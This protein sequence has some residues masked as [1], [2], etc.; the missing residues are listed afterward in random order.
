MPDIQPQITAISPTQVLL[1]LG[2][3]TAIQTGPDAHRIAQ[4]MAAELRAAGYSPVVAA[5]T[6]CRPVSPQ[7]LTPLGGSRADE[8][9]TLPEAAE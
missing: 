6:T 2:D 1:Q 4:I 5:P 8:A 9:G 3:Q 7:P